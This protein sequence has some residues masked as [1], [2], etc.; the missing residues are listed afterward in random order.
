M[1]LYDQFNQIFNRTEKAIATVTGQK[2]GGKVVASTLAGATIILTG[3]MA[4]GK[5]C[6][7]DRRSNTIL[8]EAPDVIFSE[9]GV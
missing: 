4:T 2:G 7:Y 1:S 3:E 5:K 6:Y 9:F 8:G